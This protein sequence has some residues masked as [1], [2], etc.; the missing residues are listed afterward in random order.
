M[1]L[2]F[3]LLVIVLLWIAQISAFHPSDYIQDADP[4][5]SGHL[6][7]HNLDPLVVD[8]ED[9][10]EIFVKRFKEDENFVA[11]PLTYTPFGGE[12]IVIL[13]SAQNNVRILNATTGDIL[14]MRQVQKP[15]LAAN[16]G[17][18]SVSKTMGMCLGKR[19]A[20]Y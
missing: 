14:Q 1:E 4:G 10:S 6:P 16:V 9:F 3:R 18:K 7:N 17:C 15:F 13:A 11:K 12:Q 8:S 2:S 5:H 19:R 20:S